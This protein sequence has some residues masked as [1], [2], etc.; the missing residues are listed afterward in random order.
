MIVVKDLI[1]NIYDVGYASVNEG[2]YVAIN[3]NDDV[4][5]VS[6]AGIA[7][8]TDD[9]YDKDFLPKGKYIILQATKELE[10]KCLKK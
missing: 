3:I 10:I 1:E 5:N 9:F 8:S 6:L 2:D 7:G 4:N